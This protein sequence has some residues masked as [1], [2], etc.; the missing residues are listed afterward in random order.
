MYTEAVEG[1]SA[2]FTYFSEILRLEVGIDLC[3]YSTSSK[4]TLF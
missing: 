3:C 4:E 1:N 2:S